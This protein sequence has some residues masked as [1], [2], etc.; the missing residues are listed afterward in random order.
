M[1]EDSLYLSIFVHIL[2]L[3]PWQG[4]GRCK[5]HIHGNELSEFNFWF[6]S[7]LPVITDQL[8][9]YVSSLV[10]NVMSFSTFLKGLC[11]RTIAKLPAASPPCAGFWLKKK[12][13]CNGR[14]PKSFECFFPGSYQIQCYSLCLPSSVRSG[15]LSVLGRRRSLSGLIWSWHWLPRWLS[16]AHGQAL[17]LR[18]CT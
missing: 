13:W 1:L 9:I 3:P 5:E 8:L 12:L 10:H 16:T 14:Q 7:L 18:S 11:F 4:V 2:V 15:I 6:C 17:W